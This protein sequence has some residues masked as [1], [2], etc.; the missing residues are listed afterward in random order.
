MGLLY[1]SISI[2]FLCVLFTNHF[3]YYL[4]CLCFFMYGFIIHYDSLYVKR[5]ENMLSDIVITLHDGNIYLY[6]SF[7]APSFYYIHMEENI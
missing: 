7:M 3:R 5:R 6:I 2:E 1:F 4:E